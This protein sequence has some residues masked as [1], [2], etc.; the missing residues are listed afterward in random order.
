MAKLKLALNAHM[1]DDNQNVLRM[2]HF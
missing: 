1:S 2:T